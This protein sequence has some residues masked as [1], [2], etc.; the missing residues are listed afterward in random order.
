M[1]DPKIIFSLVLLGHD[2]SRKRADIL[3]QVHQIDQRFRRSYR[4][5]NGWQIAAATSTYIDFEDRTINLPLPGVSQDR[6]TIPTVFYKI[7]SQEMNTMLREIVTAIKDWSEHSRD[8]AGSI[9]C[10]TRLTP[11][12]E[13]SILHAEPPLLITEEDDSPAPPFVEEFVPLRMSFL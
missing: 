11:E 3:F 9:L 10:E 7:Y 12:M 4:A 5:S 8:F 13:T 6:F 2:V 1:S